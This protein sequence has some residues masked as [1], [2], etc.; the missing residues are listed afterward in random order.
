MVRS[1]LSSANAGADAFGTPAAVSCTLESGVDTVSATLKAM[2]L[3]TLIDNKSSARVDSHEDWPGRF[4]FLG[5]MTAAEVVEA[6][7]AY[8][9]DRAKRGTSPNKLEALHSLAGC[10]T[11]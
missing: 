1:A 10:L 7:I 11:L 8:L 9:K 3:A 5:A 6:M 2:L 4:R